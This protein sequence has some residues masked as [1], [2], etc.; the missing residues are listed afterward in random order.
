MKLERLTI[1]NSEKL[2]LIVNLSTMFTAGIPLLEIISSLREGTKGNV[3]IILE[4]IQD[5]VTQ[6]KRLYT[7]IAKFPRVFSVVTV[8]IIKSS[9]EAGTLDVALNDLRASIKKEIEFNDKVKSAMIYPAFIFVVFIGVFLMILLVVIPKIETVFVRL[10]VELPL[11]TQILILSSRS[12]ITYPIFVV[13]GVLILFAVLTFLYKTYRKAFLQVI[14]SFPVVSSLASQIDFARFSHNLFL[15]LNAGL[16][17]NMSLEL[18]ESVVIKSNIA[19]AIK[20]AKEAVM[21]GQR[22]SVGFRSSGRVFPSILIAITE[23]G[24]KS[25]TLDKSMQDISDYYDYQVD[26]SLKKVLTLLEPIMLLMVGLM[27]GGIMLAIIGP[28][29][30]LIGKVG[31]R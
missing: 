7:S 6:G 5:D 11:V 16:P 20:V 21:S 24:E 14:F 4:T 1:S 19:K 26:S 13:I 27:V 3:K 8:N 23:S 2:S 25:G 31:A 30:S 29:Y 9:E 22:L 15:L 12:I 10:N 18:T 17:V 28:I